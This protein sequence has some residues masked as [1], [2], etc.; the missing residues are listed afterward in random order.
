[1]ESDNPYDI[2]KGILREPTAEERATGRGV[3]RG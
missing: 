1:M 2:F 3:S